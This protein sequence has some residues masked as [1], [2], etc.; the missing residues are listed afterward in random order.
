VFNIVVD[1]MLNTLDMDDCA[2]MTWDKVS[3]GLEV[4]INVN[5]SGDPDRVAPKGTRYD[6]SKYPARRFTLTERQVVVIRYD[7]E[8]ADKKEVEEL[9]R[10]NGKSRMLVPLV[11]REEARGLIQVEQQ[12]ADKPLTQQQIRLA[13]AL[14]SQ[15]A[16][17]IENA[18]LSAETAERFEELFVINELSRAISSELDLDKVIKVVR[19]QVPPLVQVDELYLALFDSETEEITFPLA[20]FSGKDVNIPPRRLGNDEVSYIIKKKQMLILVEELLSLSD[21]RRNIGII[22]S[23]EE[24]KSYMGVPLLSANQVIGVLAVRDSKKSRAFGVN[25]QGILT[26]VAAQLSAAIRNAQ[27][28]E[29]INNFAADLNRLVEA[30][31]RELEKERD[32][33]DTLYQITSELARTLD[34]DRVLERALGMVAKAV[35]ADDGVILLLDPMSDQLYSRAVLNIESLI[36]VGR[37]DRLVHP[38]EAIGAWLIEN[39]HELVVDDLHQAEYWN[40]QQKGTEQWRSALAVLLETGEDVQGVIVFLSEK[41]AQFDEPQLKLAVSAANQVAA[42]IN[43][44]DLYQLIRDQAERLGALLRSEQEEAQKSTAILE[45]IA[46]GV[47]LTDANSFVVLFNTAAERILELPRDQVLGQPL[48]TLTGLYGGSG[49]VW[50]R[51]VDEWSA[52]PERLTVGQFIDERLQLGERVVSVH[53]SPVYMTT[54]TGSQFLGTVSVFRDITKEVEVDRVKS[55]F[56][57]NVSHEFRTPMTSI[58]GFADLLL[59]G[60]VGDMDEAQKKSLAIIK[61]NAD[62]LSG[63]VNDVLEISKIDA[64]RDQLNVEIVDVPDLIDQAVKNLQNKMDVRK[65]QLHLTVDIAPDLPELQADREKLMRI[66]SNIMDNAFNYTYAGGSID[67]RV[68]PQGERMVFSVKDTGIG[69]PEE[70]QNRV[71]R[72]F[73][74]F[75]QH[76]L[77]MDVAGTG[78]GLSIVKELVELHNGQIWFESQL[79]HG[80]TFFIS[81]PLKQP[82]FVASKV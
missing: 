62:R 76:A 5:R 33:I 59:M 65:K 80:T 17:A 44:A 27:L 29:Q 73:E 12:V 40:A 20:V 77:V 60:A 39:R 13:R 56:I 67:I 42:A 24:V 68:Q 26:T 48:A 69:I 53:L 64:G 79:N 32:R 3:D 81:L 58:K 30:R 6:L 31:T 22:S 18:R 66:L 55:E 70:F 25:D 54:T 71:W 10:H 50:A 78:L 61:E 21:I 43:N 38:A 28:F 46:D 23:E 47:M 15:V 9:R 82:G 14:G 19:D 36:D 51:S 57:A 49:N 75:D 16:V 45:S 41:V 37:D 1:L 72:R 2:I 7:D 74:R 8:G 34:M 52:H 35:G 4:Q 11:V 63:L